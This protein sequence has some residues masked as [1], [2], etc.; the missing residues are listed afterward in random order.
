MQRSYLIGLLGQQMRSEN[1]GK[2]VVI[3]IPVA[4]VVERNDEEVAAMERL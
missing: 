4:P 2:Q 1:L 3:A